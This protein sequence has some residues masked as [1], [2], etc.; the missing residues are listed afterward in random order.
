MAGFAFGNP[1]YMGVGINGELKFP[2]FSKYD[3]D[4]VI[5]DKKADIPKIDIHEWAKTHGL[6]ISEDGKTLTC[7]K[8]VRKIGDRYFSIYDPKFEYK[9]GEFVN[10][11]KFD[12][13]HL[14][15]C[16]HGLHGASLKQAIIYSSGCHFYDNSKVAFLE[17]KVD[18][19]NP[20]N[21]VI[22]YSYIILDM[23]RAY[24][25]K[26]DTGYFSRSSK[27]RFKKCFVTREV[28][29]RKVYIDEE[30]GEMHEG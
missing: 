25:L 4:C 5:Y 28:K 23:D 18:I 26:S 11:E 8:V 1:N 17:L 22:P 9:I 20:D 7:Y 16:S 13:D 30:T 3:V 6:K 14:N 27:I 29:L 2:E 10:S 21:Y 15:E 19:S 24:D 12:A